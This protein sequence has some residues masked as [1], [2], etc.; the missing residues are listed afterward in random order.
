MHVMV[1]ELKDLF[2]QHADPVLAGPMSAYM[3]NQ[4][5]YLG[6]KSP[7]FNELQKQ[8][9]AAHVPPRQVDDIPF[10]ELPVDRITVWNRT[11]ARAEVISVSPRSP[12]R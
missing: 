10:A 5:P 7:S 2:E 9:L 4:F 6:I 8:F 11:A 12:S 3:R 1:A